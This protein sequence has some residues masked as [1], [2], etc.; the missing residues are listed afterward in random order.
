MLKYYLTTNVSTKEEG[1]ESGAMESYFSGKLDDQMDTSSSEN[2]L[3]DQEERENKDV[4]HD[5]TQDH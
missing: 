1:V 5:I 4:D 2:K 3:P